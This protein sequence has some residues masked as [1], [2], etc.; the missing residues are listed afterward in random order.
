MVLKTSS[1]A[2]FVSALAIISSYIPQAEAH[3]WLDCLDWRFKKPGKVD[4]SAN[5]GECMGYA[6]R[7]PYKKPFGTLDSASPSRHYEQPRKNPDKAP[8]CSE[9]KGGD[10]NETRANPPEA[11]YGGKEWGNMTTA[12]SGDQLCMRWPGKNHGDEDTKTWVQ[13]NFA[14]V[15]NGPDPTQQELLNNTLVPQLLYQNCTFKGNSDEAKDKRP[16]GGCFTVPP[17]EDGIYLIQWRWMLNKNEWYTSC[18]DINIV[19]GNST[20]GG[21]S[22]SKRTSGMGHRLMKGGGASHKIM[23]D[24]KSKG[25]HAAK[26]KRQ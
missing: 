20:G 12:K 23:R 17:R 6:R 26:S 7:Y 18:A 8:P 4:W 1:V 21:N 13:V 3:S 22:T 9:G 14:T 16:C 19:G 5:G 24:S 25:K 10:S 11:A 15:R 2:I